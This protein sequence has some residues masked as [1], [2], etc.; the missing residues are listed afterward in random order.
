MSSGY[1]GHIFRLI[2]KLGVNGSNCH[3]ADSGVMIQLQEKHVRESGMPCWLTL[4]GIYD[5]R[6]VIIFGS[7]IHIVH[8]K[9]DFVA[10]QCANT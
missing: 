2:C 5:T 6:T 7:T 10:N 3:H 9:W 4:C 8:H 1:C